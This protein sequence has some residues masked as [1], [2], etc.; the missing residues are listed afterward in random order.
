ME[1][2]RK[3]EGQGLPFEQSS[4]HSEPEG[5]EKKRNTKLPMKIVGKPE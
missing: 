3:E 4:G 5:R 2:S 1:V